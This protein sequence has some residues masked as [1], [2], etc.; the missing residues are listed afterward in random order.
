MSLHPNDS[1]IEIPSYI[2]DLRTNP[3]FVTEALEN[4]AISGLARDWIAGYDV[5]A[6]I[7]DIVGAYLD[8][9]TAECIEADDPHRAFRA[10][11]DA[12]YVA[13]RAAA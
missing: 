10:L 13:E 5:T 7:A 2:L 11:D 12:F 9:R 1:G 6:G 8:K 4:G 3:V